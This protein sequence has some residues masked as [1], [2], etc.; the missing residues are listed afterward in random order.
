ME[1][2]WSGGNGINGIF[3]KFN[4]VGFI[5]V[6]CLYLGFEYYGVGNL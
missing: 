3:Y 6:F 1:N 4:F 5:L 2:G